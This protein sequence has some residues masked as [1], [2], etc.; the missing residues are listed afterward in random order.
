MK[1]LLIIAPVAVSLA[2]AACGEDDRARELD[3]G[4]AADTNDVPAVAHECRAWTAE[5]APLF[6]DLHVHTRLSLDAN[7][8]GTRLGPADAYRFARARRSASN[9]IARMARRSGACSSNAR[10]T[11]RR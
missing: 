8:Q 10:S 2:F 4:D 7:L 11:S 6:G 1:R 9:R 3:V 5:R